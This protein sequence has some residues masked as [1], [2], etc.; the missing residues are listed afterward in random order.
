[1]RN[2]LNSLKNHFNRNRFYY[3]VAVGSVT[4]TAGSI[5]LI[6]VTREWNDF[7]MDNVVPQMTTN[8]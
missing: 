1:M 5:A 8:Q 3:G 4:T 6:K 2:K 7:Y